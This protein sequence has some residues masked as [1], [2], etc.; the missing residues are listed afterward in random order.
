MQTP[1]SISILAPCDYEDALPYILLATALHKA[2]YNVKVLASNEHKQ[3][4]QESG[5]ISHVP[6]HPDDVEQQLR[7]DRDINEAIAIKDRDLLFYLTKRKCKRIARQHC[8]SI[9]QELAT[10]PP[11]LFIDGNLRG[12]FGL[13]AKTVLSIPSVRVDLKRAP[14]KFECAES[15]SSTY[16]L[17]WSQLDNAM[18]SLDC[19]SLKL[20]GLSC[21][22]DQKLPLLVYSGSVPDDD[23]TKKAADAID[24]CV[25]RSNKEDDSALVFDTALEMFGYSTDSAE[26]LSSICCYDVTGC[27]LKPKH[28]LEYAEHAKCEAI[29]R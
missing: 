15:A 19:E 24:E 26:V 21:D 22:D 4:I 11:S 2:G 10:N 1:N 29:E 7:S 3:T 5:L 16:S 13:Y 18:I 8:S 20:T 27:F 23:G 12:Y 9:V 17:S 25:A 6:I 14:S 28:M